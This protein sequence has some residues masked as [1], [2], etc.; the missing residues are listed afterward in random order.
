MFKGV[1]EML[2]IGFIAIVLIFIAGIYSVIDYFWLAD[3]YESKKQ[4]VP[5]VII[6]TENRNGIVKNDTTYIYTFN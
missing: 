3:K 5:E 4:I 6:K 1:G 2:V